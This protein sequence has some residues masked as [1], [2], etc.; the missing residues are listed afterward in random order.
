V[1]GSSLLGASAGRTAVTVAPGTSTWIA[2]CKVRAS[3]AVTVATDLK[4]LMTRRRVV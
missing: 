1:V 3:V 2:V 4:L